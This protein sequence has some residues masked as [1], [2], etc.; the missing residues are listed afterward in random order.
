V[1]INSKR[2]NGYSGRGLNNMP[3][4]NEKLKI[5]KM[6]AEHKKFVVEY[7]A[8]AGN[9]TE[10]YMKVFP[11]SKYNSARVEAS[12]L[13]SRPNILQAIE[14]EYAKYF[15][16]KDKEIAKSKTYQLI[17]FCGDVDVADI[18]DDDYEIRPLSEIPIP[19]RRA[20]QSIKK[21]EKTNQYGVDRTVEV[22]L[23]N[24]LAALELRAKMQH[25]LDTK[26][27]VGDNVTITVGLAKRPV[28]EDAE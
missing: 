23:V 18:F 4:K 22:N 14:D 11:K 5:D 15:K 19:I 1:A 28:E 7:V 24:K 10:A 8:C 20:I 13:L 6:S 16:E 21:T 25:M 27:D 17:N 2:K 3:K 9:G 26:L 12:R